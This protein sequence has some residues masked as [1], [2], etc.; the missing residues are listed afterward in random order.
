MLIQ[1]LAYVPDGS[2][3]TDVH[4][5]KCL[6]VDVFSEKSLH[7]LW[8]DVVGRSWPNMNW[9]YSYIWFLLILVCIECLLIFLLVSSDTC[10]GEHFNRYSIVNNLK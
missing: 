8:K 6:P 2:Y 3:I 7:L 4:G 9:I 10:C 5:F 1:H